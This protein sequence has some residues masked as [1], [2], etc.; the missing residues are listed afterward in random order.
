M[1]MIFHR[2]LHVL[3]VTLFILRTFLSKDPVK[4][5]KCEY[6]IGHRPSPATRQRM[7]QLVY[8]PW[9]M[10]QAPISSSILYFYVSS[11]Q[12]SRFPYPS[13]SCQLLSSKRLLVAFVFFVQ[14]FLQTFWV[15]NLHNTQHFIILYSYTSS[16][17]NCINMP[18]KKQLHA[19][20]GRCANDQKQSKIPLPVS[21]IIQITI[22][23]CI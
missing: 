2:C 23:L 5:S 9:T 7:V 13:S 4:L 20:V 21:I 17:I 10:V 22:F 14:V 18:N 1:I 6:A 11:S 12:F 15:Y 16:A 8:T 3:S 19:K